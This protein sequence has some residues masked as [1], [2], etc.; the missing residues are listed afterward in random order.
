MIDDPSMVGALGSRARDL[1][2]GLGAA[3]A[4]VRGS[5]AAA[6]AGVALLGVVALTVA[7]RA[8]RVLAGLGGAAAGALGAYAF[9]GGLALH[10]GFSASTSAL[11]GAAM[12]GLLSAALPR[13]FPFVAAA[14]PAAM[15]GL[16][17]P[18]A[19]RP[20]AGALAG[21]AV[22]GLLA[23]AFARSV[24][25]V[26]ASVGGGLLLAVGGL[27]LLERYPLA[28]AAASRPVVVLGVALVLAVAGT[29]LQLERRT[30]PA[31][32]ARRPADRSIS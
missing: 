21:A 14:I 2:A 29:A 8:E 23:A 9:R 10:L 32:D 31:L 11:A 18:I 7:G 30:P 25:I 16:G 4:L 24:S 13:L 3:T 12:C 5:G 19:G 22:G 20:W 6:A 26:L 17:V 27:A 15:L 28:A 1:L